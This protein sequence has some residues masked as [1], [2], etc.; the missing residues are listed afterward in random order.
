MKT[1]WTERHLRTLSDRAL[2]TARMIERC[3]DYG[4]CP[5][6]EQFDTAYLD[7]LMRACEYLETR[8]ALRDCAILNGGDI[9]PQ[10]RTS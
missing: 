10:R 5:E 7:R 6:Q 4:P 9:E 2:D 1:T 8:H 3:E